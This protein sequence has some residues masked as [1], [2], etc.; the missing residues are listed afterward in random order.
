LEKNKGEQKLIE[1]LAT[2]PSLGHFHLI[3]KI[4]ETECSDN[5]NSPSRERMTSLDFSE[6]DDEIQGLSPL[7][8][9]GR[10]S[11]QA[12]AIDRLS[13]DMPDMENG[14]IE[15]VTSPHNKSSS[16]FY[17]QQKLNNATRSF[18]R[19]SI[20]KMDTLTEFIGFQ[21]MKESF[22]FQVSPRQYFDTN[23]DGSRIVVQSD[24]DESSEED[25]VETFIDL[26]FVALLLQLGKSL[27]ACGYSTDNTFGAI[28]VFSIC[29]IARYSMDDWCNRFL[30]DTAGFRFV[31]LAFMFGVALMCTNA[32]LLSLEHGDS[33]ASK[34]CVPLESSIN[35][36]FVLGLIITRIVILLLYGVTL[37]QYPMAWPQ[38]R[39][40]VIIFT[41]GLGLCFSVLGTV[42]GHWDDPENSTLR[43]LFYALGLFEIFFTFMGDFIFNLLRKWAASPVQSLSVSKHLDA[44]KKHSLF[45]NDPNQDGSLKKRLE[46]TD[47]WERGRRGS[48][49][50]I[51]GDT[52]ISLLDADNDYLL[53]IDLHLLVQRHSLLIFVTLGEVRLRCFS[54]L[55]PSFCF[56][57]CTYY[58]LNH[59]TLNNYLSLSL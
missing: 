3:A 38:L 49:I 42:L 26:F 9:A 45:G 50:T 20:K 15:P 12:A 39:C 7:E 4:M 51:F 2:K 17:G 32:S 25:W 13:N 56:H 11:A 46:Q 29:Y 10:K 22:F 59:S 31:Y 1:D 23:L 27:N 8:M 57:T 6:L 5:S 48:A 43:R 53:P 41:V 37:Y 36:F 44:K 16:L 40:R 35:L 18:M 28:M 55:Q 52:R 34:D 33:Y 19:M 21:A 30:P 24:P 58:L 54:R 14:S 47:I